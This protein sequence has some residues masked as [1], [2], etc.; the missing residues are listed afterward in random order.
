MKTISIMNLK[1]GVGKTVS[2]CNIA[3]ILAAVY[4]K[5]V[6]VV[7]ND[8][9]GNTSRF[10]HCHNYDKFS[11]AD[12]LI[13][14][15]ID[16]QKV[17]QN[18]EYENLNLIQANTML[19]KANVE[20]IN[21]AS[22]PKETR[23]QNALELVADN[24]DYCIIDNAPEINMATIN[25][26]V[27][28]DEVLI[29]LTVDKFAIDGLDEIYNQIESAKEFNENLCVRGCFVTQWRNNHVNRQYEEWLNEQDKFKVFNTHIRRTE[30]ITESTFA[31]QPIVLF[32]RRSA[33]AID[34][35]KLVAEY[36]EGEE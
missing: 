4:D 17:I 28:S 25:A 31:E 23:L 16:M 20:I 33:A 7:D 19:M 15:K 36:L 5:R 11:I 6:L 22:R 32:S 13:L 10:F 30:K 14:Q 18:T 12:V 1:G 24:Y 8:K 2:A 35:L 21:D 3:Y 9:Q 34:Y 29:P 27:T 26:L